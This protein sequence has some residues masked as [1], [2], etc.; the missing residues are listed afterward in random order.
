MSNP[1]TPFRLTLCTLCAHC[2]P[3]G[4]PVRLVLHR[5]GDRVGPG[6][7]ARRWHHVI[8]WPCLKG[9]WKWCSAALVCPWYSIGMPA[10]LFLEQVRIV[11]PMLLVCLVLSS[12]FY[13]LWTFSENSEQQ[14]ISYFLI[15]ISIFFPLQQ[16]LNKD[17]RFPPFSSEGIRVLSVLSVSDL[18][19]AAGSI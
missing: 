8:F 17:Y 19:R 16:I 9:R 3:L 12:P 11:L 5:Y 13:L 14:F 10:C 18:I 6:D 1:K 2:A 7:T 15:S 4:E